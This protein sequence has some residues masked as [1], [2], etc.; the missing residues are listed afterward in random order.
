[1][2]VYQ[3]PEIGGWEAP[4]IDAKD[5][6]DQL[7]AQG[8]DV[9]V[10]LDPDMARFERDTEAFFRSLRPDADVM[11]YLNG[12][13]GLVT[14][15]DTGQHMSFL[16][17]SDALMHDG[18]GG[19][20]LLDPILAQLEQCQP[21]SRLVI[22]DTSSLDYTEEASAPM[23]GSVAAAANCAAA[24]PA[25]PTK[26]AIFQASTAARGVLFCYAAELGATAYDSLPGMRNGPFARELLQRLPS[27]T[28]TRE[29]LLEVSEAV[30]HLTGDR[31]VPY[32]TSTGDT[33]PF[34]LS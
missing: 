6:A 29:L 17:M 8:F 20:A 26:G 5:L 15:P 23:A 10:S 9:T 13:G 4:A 32:V 18:G 12:A 21:H 34:D 16:L 28:P 3:Q 14:M 11:I 33:P 2:G 24:T 27:R 19:V 7:K 25:T 1:M 22:M 31:Q 30:R